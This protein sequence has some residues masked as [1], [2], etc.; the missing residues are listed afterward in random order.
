V[1]LAFQAAAGR[2]PFTVAA[3]I[4]LYIEALA[5]EGRKTTDT[6]K[7]ASAMI[8]PTLGA[9]VVSDLTTESLR[10]W[11]TKLAAA[12]PRVRTAKGA[13]QRYR[14]AAEG[15]DHQ[16]AGRRRRSTANRHFAI[17]RAPR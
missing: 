12:P 3:A 17:L 11:L 9:E 8:L 4:N 16:E 14:K 1:T 6:E 7:R 15:E 10:N 5:A 13:A 2:G